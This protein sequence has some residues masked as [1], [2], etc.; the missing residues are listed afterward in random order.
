MRCASVGIGNRQRFTRSGTR[1]TTHLLDAN[2]PVHVVR[3]RL[4]HEDP[5]D[6][7]ARMCPARP[8]HPKLAAADALD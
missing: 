1:T 7:P 2:V 4:G 5:A 8:R 6:R 3:A